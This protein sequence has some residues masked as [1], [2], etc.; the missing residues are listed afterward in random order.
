[1]FGAT[2]AA[3]EG[4]FYLVLSKFA[5][6]LFVATS[7]APVLGAFGIVAWIREAPWLHVAIWFGSAA[8]ALFICLAIMF[9]ATQQLEKES[10]VIKSIKHADAEVLAFLLTY[11]LPLAGLQESV[12]TNV[13]VVAYVFIV[14]AWTVYHSHAFH[15]NPLLGVAGYHFYEVES[16]D[17]VCLM[18]V[19]RRAI[20]RSTLTTQAVHMFDYTFLDLGD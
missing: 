3:S 10:L 8:I 1:M 16:T 18:L 17:G 6:L 5:K 20:R 19:S 9:F 13:P 14:I 7:L 4:F 2:T 15:F 12:L 11:L